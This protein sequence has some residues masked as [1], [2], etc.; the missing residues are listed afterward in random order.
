MFETAIKRR[1]WWGEKKC[2]AM[3]INHIDVWCMW[4]KTPLKWEIQRFEL[5]KRLINNKNRLIETYYVGKEYVTY[6]IKNE[7]NNFYLKPASVSQVKSNPV[8]QIYDPSF[9]KYH[10]SNSSF[11][12]R[13]EPPLFHN[14]NPPPVYNCNYPLLYN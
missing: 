13:S 4:A 5:N 11:L 7:R 1:I 3:T 6:Y 8:F 12:Y 2:N 9:Q 10:M 14:I